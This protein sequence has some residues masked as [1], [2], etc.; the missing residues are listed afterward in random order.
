MGQRKRKYVSL[1]YF[2]ILEARAS[3]ESGMSEHN[4]SSSTWN[5]SS[6][7]AGPITHTQCHAAEVGDVC[8]ASHNGYACYTGPAG[9]AEYCFTSSIY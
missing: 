9:P 4:C 6:S 2:Q 8:H 3:L 5:I 7:S 1:K